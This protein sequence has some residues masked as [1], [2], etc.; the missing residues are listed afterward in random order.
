M[1]FAA[2]CELAAAFAS[3]ELSVLRNLLGNELTVF[4]IHNITAEE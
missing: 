1:L 2:A 4:L 3:G